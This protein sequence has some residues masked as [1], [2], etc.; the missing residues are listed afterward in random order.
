MDA[1]IFTI[2][3]PWT[4]IHSSE[5]TTD[6]IIEE[7]KVIQTSTRSHTDSHTGLR[8]LPEIIK[9]IYF[10]FCSLSMVFQ[11]LIKIEIA[12]LNG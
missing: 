7:V 4:F 2:H 3:S 9:L 6:I 5:F 10:I 8:P 12:K 1:D 11:L